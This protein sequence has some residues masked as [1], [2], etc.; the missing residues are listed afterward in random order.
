VKIFYPKFKKEDLIEI[1]SQRILKLKEDLPIVRVFLF[2]SYAKGNYKV[3]SDIDILIIYKGKPIKDAYKLTKLK[4]CI[5][6]LEP[7]IYSEEEFK[8]ME[9]KINKMLEGGILLYSNES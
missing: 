8:N 9:Y 5:P 3:G 7:H 1:L 2:G 4:L 6:R